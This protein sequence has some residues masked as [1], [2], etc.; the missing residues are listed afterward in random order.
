M[1]IDGFLRFAEGAVKWIDLAAVALGLVLCAYLS[2]AFLWPDA[3]HRHGGA[4]QLLFVLIVIPTTVS[5][6]LAWLGMCRRA[7]WRWW[8]QLLP[9]AVFFGVGRLFYTSLG[10]S[11]WAYSFVAGLPLI[12]ACAYGFFGRRSSR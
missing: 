3:G 5:A 9:V 2:P 10:D 6:F 4:Y 1:T 8:A 7:A 12:A 11:A